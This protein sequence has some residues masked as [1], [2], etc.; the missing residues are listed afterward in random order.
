M[1]LI[2]LTILLISLN[3][4]NSSKKSV[5]QNKVVQQNE[6]QTMLTGT[7]HI[8]LVEGLSKI[9]SN[10]EIS[11]NEKDHTVSGFSGCNRFSGTYKVAA[12]SLSLGP[13]ATTRKMCPN[14]QEENAVLEALQQVD[15]YRMENETLTLQ[16]G[17]KTLVT[18]SK[19]NT[20]QNPYTIEYSALTRGMQKYYTVKG[21]SITLKSSA[22]QKRNQKKLTEP[23]LEK[24]VRMVS[25]LNLEELATLEAPSNK[26][27][28]D[29]AAIGTLKIMY[30][31]KTYI[32][33][34]F[35]D[36]NPNSKIADVVNY[37][38]SSVQ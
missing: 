25:Q 17:E 24:L 4:C 37:I 7:Y 33:A 11:F 26:R 16:K 31:G 30:N 1:K 13:L 9:T 32:S 21:N 27:A 5:E 34:P 22:T 12:E 6:Q 28:S 10:V 20:E 38:T 8:N 19:V 15:S 3:A 35:D 18:A 29:G 36:G 2:T 14:M 23:E